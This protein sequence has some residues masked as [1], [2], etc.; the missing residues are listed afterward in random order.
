MA[1]RKVRFLAARVV[2]KRRT[3]GTSPVANV[4][5]GDTSYAQPSLQNGA[6]Q[7]YALSAVVLVVVVEAWARDEPMRMDRRLPW[8]SHFHWKL[9]VP[10]QDIQIGLVALLH[11]AD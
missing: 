7:L 5:Y 9:S 3:T 1:G 10:W 2:S 11:S 6:V 8:N 4:C